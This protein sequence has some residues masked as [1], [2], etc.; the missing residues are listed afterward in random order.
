MVP[1]FDRYLC[2]AAHSPYSNMGILLLRVH[3]NGSSSLW[4]CCLVLLWSNLLRVEHNRPPP[5][6][7]IVPRIAVV[8]FCEVSLVVWKAE[9]GPRVGGEADG[10]FLT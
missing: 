8:I 3:H 9:R 7:R 2:Y 5:L 4:Q 10:E 6:C 1:H